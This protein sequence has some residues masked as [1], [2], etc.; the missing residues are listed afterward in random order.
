MYLL[1]FK[2]SEIVDLS[3][4]RIQI[5]PNNKSGDKL[6]LQFVH[7]AHPFGCL[8][9]CKCSWFLGTVSTLIFSIDSEGFAVPDFDLASRKDADTLVA[10]SA[11]QNATQNSVWFDFGAIFELTRP[12]SVCDDESSCIIYR[13][14]LNAGLV[15]WLCFRPLSDYLE[16]R[17]SPCRKMK[18][19]GS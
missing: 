19:M 3:W 15:M 6:R 7:E 5:V 12:R 13:S 8:L 1:A 16:I 9:P 10:S 18:I 11:V 2:S 17:P 4:F 14:L